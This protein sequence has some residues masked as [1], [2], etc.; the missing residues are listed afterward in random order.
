VTGNRTPHFLQFKIKKIY[1]RERERITPQIKFWT[2]K[3]G[4]EYV[5]RNLNSNRCTVIGKNLLSNNIKITSCCELGANIGLNLDAIKKI[6]NCDTFGIEVNKK[7]FDI[8]KS[9]HKS[10][11]QTIL[12][13]RLKKKFDIVLSVGVLI[14]QKPS[15]LRSF[16]RLLYKLSKKYIYIS[17]YFNPVPIKIKYR[18]HINKLFKRDFAKEFWSLYPKM[19]LI[20][21][22]F[23]WKEDPFKKGSCDNDNWFIFKKK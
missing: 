3:F 14:H 5:D 22:G 13:Y 23:N 9:K 15:D 6:Y 8:L 1:E 4:N 19:K 18:G 16:Y 2:E 21:Y 10:A 11:N 17:E 12:S 20:N 7:A